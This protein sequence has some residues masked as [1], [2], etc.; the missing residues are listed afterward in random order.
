MFDYSRIEEVYNKVCT[1]GNRFF[2]LIFGSLKME[3]I[4]SAKII[5][6]KDDWKRCLYIAE[7]AGY[8]CLCIIELEDKLSVIFS[9]MHD[10][11]RAKIE[12]CYRR[13]FAEGFFLGRKK[14]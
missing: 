13:V 7:E 10:N 9:I 3:E 12:E 1:D 6:P 4:N 8:N 11:A 2:V 14:E 5:G